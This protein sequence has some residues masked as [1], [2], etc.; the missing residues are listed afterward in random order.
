MELHGIFL[1]NSMENVL[2]L[3]G[4]Y[5]WR[6]F[7]G[8]WFPYPKCPNPPWRHFPWNSWNEFHGGFSQGEYST[9]L[10]IVYSYI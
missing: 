3:Y 2:I 6:N 8:N 4:K 7:H 5:R 10:F 9:R 1:R